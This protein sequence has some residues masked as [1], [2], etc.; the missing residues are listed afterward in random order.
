[1][2]VR[3]DEELEERERES[4]VVDLISIGYIPT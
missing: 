2:V 3:I 4:V 1:M